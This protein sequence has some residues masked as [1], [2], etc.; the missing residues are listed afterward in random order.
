MGKHV[1]Y[2]RPSF[3]YLKDYKWVS[4]FFAAQTTTYQKENWS[5][6][7]FL[8]TAWP[9]SDMPGTSYTWNT[10]INIPF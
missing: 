7:I 8:T 1:F 6:N 5:C 9:I 3:F 2:T 4:G 10:G